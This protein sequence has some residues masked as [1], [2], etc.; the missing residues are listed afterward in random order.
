M[1]T[2]MTEKINSNGKVMLWINTV[3][4]GVILGMLSWMGV[5]MWDKL[6]ANSNQLILVEERQSIV[7]RSLPIMASEIDSLEKAVRIMENRLAQREHL[8]K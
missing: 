6:E 8:I 2:A 3:M 5:R 7:L 1:E 4:T